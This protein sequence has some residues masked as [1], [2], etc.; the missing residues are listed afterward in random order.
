MAV[1]MAQ[2]GVPAH[3]DPFFP[4]NGRIFNCGGDGLGGYLTHK[5]PPLS[6]RFRQVLKN[7]IIVRNKVK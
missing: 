7:G 2:D 5:D 1:G 4:G 3:G 6:I